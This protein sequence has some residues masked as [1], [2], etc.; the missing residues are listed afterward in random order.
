M[1]VHL[2]NPR[3]LGSL[4]SVLSVHGSPVQ[5]FYNVDCMEATNNRLKPNHLHHLSDGNTPTLLKSESL[6]ILKLLQV[7]HLAE[8]DRIDLLQK[9]SRLILN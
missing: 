7:S 4:G 1:C 3:S 9:K 8:H 2:G 5:L 6:P